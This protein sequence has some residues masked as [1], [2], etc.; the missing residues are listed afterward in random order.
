MKRLVLLAGL[1]L[2]ESA[3]ALDVGQITVNGMVVAATCSVTLGGSANPVIQLPN[4]PV[5][6]LAQ[7]GDASGDTNVDLVLSG[8][9]LTADTTVIPYFVPAS[10]L[11]PSGGRL[12]NVAAT[13]PASNVELQVLA[14][15]I[16]LNLAGAKGAQNAG[17]LYI[18]RILT[19][20][21][22]RFVVRY[23]ATGQSTAGFVNSS[24]TWGVDYN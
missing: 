5:S 2:G 9:S 24:M 22:M 21:S 19:G 23:Y 13:S 1:L 11:S 17:S 7:A 6:S 8:C 18:Q 4:V 16:A 10:N 3:Y 14:G 12:R 20:G 15:G